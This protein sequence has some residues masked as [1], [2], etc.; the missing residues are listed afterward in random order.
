[1]LKANVTDEYIK[2]YDESIG[3]VIGAAPRHKHWLQPLELVEG[4]H[5]P[6]NDSLDVAV[7]KVKGIHPATAIVKLGIH[8][9]DWVY[10]NVWHLSDAIVLGFPPIPM[11]NEPVL[12]AARAEIHTFVVPRH[13]NAIH[14]I[15][16]AIP[17]GGFSGGVAIHEGGDALGVVT[18][19]LIQ[20]H[21]P[22]QL[23]F[24][25]VLSIEA[26][27]QCLMGAS[28]FP[29]VQQE[30]HEKVMGISTETSQRLGEFISDVDQRLTQ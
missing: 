7:F 21:E 4:P 8:W 2:D 3:G 28:L 11:V 18:S 17:R 27:V 26:I 10:R 5:F 14:F 23:G 6:M 13:A 29:R 25:S 19:S 20:N 9:D 24:F 15:L 1:M 22:E 16:S 12:V 30:H